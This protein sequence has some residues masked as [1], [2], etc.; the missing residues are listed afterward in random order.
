MHEVLGFDDDVMV[1]GG[2]HA[3]DW[4]GIASGCVIVGDRPVMPVAVFWPDT[5][6]DGI[7]TE[8]GTKSPQDRMVEHLK[9]VGLRVGLVTD[10]ERWTLV[11]HQVGENPGFA[12]WWSSLWG[13]RRSL[14]GPSG[15]CCIKTASLRSARTRPSAPCLTGRPRISAVTTK[16]GNQTLEAV[17][18]L[19]RSIDRIDHERGGDLLLEES[20]RRR[21]SPNSMTLQSR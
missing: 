17:E 6:V 21:G 9:D 10:G 8:F 1:W 2:D 3:L 4:A 18:I 16:L 19:I 11:S 5:P 15:R 14:S 7:L 12:T 13:K 20:K